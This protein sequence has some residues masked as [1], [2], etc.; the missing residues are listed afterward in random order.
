MKRQENLI[1]IIIFILTEIYDVDLKKKVSHVTIMYVI[2]ISNGFLSS[3][4]VHFPNQFKL[5]VQE[6]SLCSHIDETNIKE[7]PIT[8]VVLLHGLHFISA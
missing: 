2:C 3:G 4:L 7:G 5:V 1:S 6:K 8:N